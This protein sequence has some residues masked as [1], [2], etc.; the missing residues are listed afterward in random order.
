MTLTV[1]TVYASSGM[2]TIACTFVFK[3]R[4]STLNQQIAVLIHVRLG[5]LGCVLRII[6]R[7]DL[8]DA[9]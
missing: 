5:P 6:R 9:R 1:R 8:N 7:A 3:Q 2:W 4:H